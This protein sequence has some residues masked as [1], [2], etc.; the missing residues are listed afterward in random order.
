MNISGKH[1]IENSGNLEKL[2]ALRNKAEK[3]I[4]KWNITVRESFK[5]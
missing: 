4:K 3:T 2:K 5:K 1:D